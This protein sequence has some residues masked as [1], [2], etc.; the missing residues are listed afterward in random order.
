MVIQNGVWG[1]IT[2]CY[3]K[4]WHL[5][6]ENTDVNNRNKSYP[7]TSG[8]LLAFWISNSGSGSYYGQFYN[9]HLLLCWLH[10]G[11][12][13]NDFEKVYLRHWTHMAISR[14]MISSETCFR[15]FSSNSISNLQV[16][17]SD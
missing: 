5:D 1:L 14:F 17:G 12:E 9:G 16:L 3:S 8:V 10:L 11:S 13:S 4:F 7:N 15:I 6:L 2:R